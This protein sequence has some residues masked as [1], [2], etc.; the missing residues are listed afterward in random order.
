M[1]TFRPVGGT[2]SSTIVAVTVLSGEYESAKAVCVIVGAKVS[3]SGATLATLYET[4]PVDAI[5]P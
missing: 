1:L 4:S 3:G 2:P 5:L